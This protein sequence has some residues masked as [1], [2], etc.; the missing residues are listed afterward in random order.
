MLE[1]GLPAQLQILLGP[2]GG[3]AGTN[4]RGGITAQKAGNC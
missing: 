1:D 2:V 4:A 3:H